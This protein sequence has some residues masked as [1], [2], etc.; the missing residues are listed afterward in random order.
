MTGNGAHADHILPRSLYVG[1][2]GALMVLTILTVA[3]AFVDLGFLNIVV[4]LG[5]AVVKASLV[6]LFFMHVKYSS[7]LTWVVIGSGLF[8]LAILLSLLM[9]DYSSRGWML[10]P[11]LRH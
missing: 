7:K 4:A 2:F 5:I 6:V 10:V 8:W 9:L 3:A 11:P 1:I